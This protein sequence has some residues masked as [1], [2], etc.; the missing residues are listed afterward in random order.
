MPRCEISHFARIIIRAIEPFRKLAHYF[1][2]SRHYFAPYWSRAD[3][4]VRY[5]DVGQPLARATAQVRLAGIR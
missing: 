4:D 2:I 3:D 1:G 5:A